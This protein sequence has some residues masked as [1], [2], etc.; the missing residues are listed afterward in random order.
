MGT[1]KAEYIKMVDAE[2]AQSKLIC[3][4]EINDCNNKPKIEKSEYKLLIDSKKRFLEA[5]EY[6]NLLE[7]SKRSFET[8]MLEQ[9]RLHEAAEFKSMV[10]A[11]K[12]QYKLMCQTEIK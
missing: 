7:L 3:Q 5:E 8:E 1:E 10:D 6:Q 4:P 12:A 9:K 2:K 11:E